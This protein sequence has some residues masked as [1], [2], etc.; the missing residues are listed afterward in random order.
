MSITARAPTAGPYRIANSG[1]ADKRGN[2]WIENDNGDPICLVGNVIWGNDP[3]QIRTDAE[4]ILIC[5]NADYIEV[6]S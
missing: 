6:A 3:A 5:L 4:H 2:I 1:H